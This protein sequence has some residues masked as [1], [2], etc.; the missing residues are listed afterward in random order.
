[1]FDLTQFRDLILIPSLKAIDMLSDRAVTLLLA[2]MAQESQ[3]GKYVSQIS[4]PARGV[5]QMEK[6]TY[7]DLLLNF[8]ATHPVLT[9]KTLEF[10]G[11]S[12]LPS[13]DEMVSNLK[14]A[15]II[16]R[17]FYFRVPHELPDEHDINGVWEYYKAHWNTNLGAATK[18]QFLQNYSRYILLEGRN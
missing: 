10:C 4:G 12:Q 11:F 18:E 8:F 13:A 17:V 7:N 16:A 9:K 6:N 3:F 1:M 14:F 5:F 2:T 15:C